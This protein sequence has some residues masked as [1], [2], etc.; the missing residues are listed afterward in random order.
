MTSSGRCTQGVYFTVQ[1]I[2][3]EMLGKYKDKNAPEYF[4]I[5][6]TEGLN[7]PEKADGLF[8]R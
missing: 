5:I 4:I 6:D 1:K 2:P 8:D 3:E 7:S